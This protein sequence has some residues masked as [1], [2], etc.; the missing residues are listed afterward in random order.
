MFLYCPH[1]FVVFSLLEEQLQTHIKENKLKNIIQ[2]FLIYL[3]QL[4]KTLVEIVVQTSYLPILRKDLR[5]L[6]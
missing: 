1:D 4:V 5:A 6:I 2:V 3:L